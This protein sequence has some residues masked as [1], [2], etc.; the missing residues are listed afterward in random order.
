MPVAPPQVMTTKMSPDI[1]RCLLGGKTVP[2]ET[3]EMEHFRV[4]R[5]S[6][7]YLVAPCHFT[8]VGN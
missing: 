8:S 1:A 5:N 2:L 3:T 7:I 4:G 6:G